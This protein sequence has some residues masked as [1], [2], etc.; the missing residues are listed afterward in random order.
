MKTCRSIFL[1]GVAAVGGLLVLA[2]SSA[3]SAREVY[4]SVGI[5][6]PGVQLGV[7]N[8]PPVLHHRRVVPPPVYYSAPHAVYYSAPPPVYYYPP[9]VYSQP[10]TFYYAPP[11]VVYQPAPYYVQQPSVT[12][13]HG[14]LGWPRHYWR[15]DHW[16][17]GDHMRGFNDGRY[18]HRHR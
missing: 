17:R 4:W 18:F 2:A 8:A 15:H 16:D 9:Q 10:Q 3:V 6:S 7:S 13:P 12:L 14:Q 11:Q 5:G 1:R